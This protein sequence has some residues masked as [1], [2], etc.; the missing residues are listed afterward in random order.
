M[1]VG[2]GP[3]QDIPSDRCRA[4]GDGSAVVV[5][6]GGQVVAFQNRCLHQDSPLAGGVVLDGVLICPLHFWRYRLPAGA[7]VGSGVPLPGYPVEVV[8]GEVWVEVPDPAPPLSMREMLLKHAREWRPG[9]EVKAVV[10]DMGGVFR[11][12]FTEPLVEIGEREGW[13]PIPLG[14]TGRVPDPEYW[15]MAEGE[16]DEP[17]YLQI[18]VDRLRREGFALDPVTDVDWEAEDRP[19]VWEAIARIADSPLRQAILTN[20]AT[21]WM[22]AN[23]WERWGPARYF[24]EVIDVATLGVR[25][26]HPATYREVTHRLALDPVE[27]VFVDDMP[28][29]CRGAEAVGMRSLWFDIT[30]PAT[31]VTR[32]LKLIRLEEDR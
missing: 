18:I 27:C 6:V 1:R 8:D 2:A 21:R 31:S 30:R 22:G 9:P 3:L 19:E 14:P 4:V 24:D 17:E 15:A 29:N 12:Y 20:D 7:H 28:A 25:K 26:P 13:P 10:W 23:W 11:R 32:L 5:R 16:I